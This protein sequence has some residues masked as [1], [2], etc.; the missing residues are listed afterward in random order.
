MFWYLLRF[1]ICPRHIWKAAELVLQTQVRN[2]HCGHPIIVVFRFQYKKFL[3]SNN[4]NR[5]ATQN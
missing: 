2:S 1:H 4:S 3:A 5:A